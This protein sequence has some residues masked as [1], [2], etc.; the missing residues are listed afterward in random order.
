[1]YIYGDKSV[2]SNAKLSK[3]KLREIFGTGKDI[4]EEITYVRRRYKAHKE[5]S[6]QG[7]KRKKTKQYFEKR[8]YPKYNKK[9][10]T[11]WL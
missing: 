2:P 3:R 6:Q 5:I 8:D 4:T 1:M 7:Q 9:G 11:I 10:R